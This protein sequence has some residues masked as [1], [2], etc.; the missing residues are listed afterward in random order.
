MDVSIKIFFLS[1]FQFEDGY[2]KTVFQIC[3]TALH[4]ILEKLENLYSFIT[5]TVN[6]TFDKIAK[7]TLCFIYDSPSGGSILSYKAVLMH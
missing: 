5:L 6:V 3:H 1:F 2:L 4:M 7:Y